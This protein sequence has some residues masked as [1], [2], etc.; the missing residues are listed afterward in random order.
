MGASPIREAKD[1]NNAKDGT[2]PSKREAQKGFCGICF[3]EAGS[4]TKRLG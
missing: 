3:A 1:S 4:S 2:Y